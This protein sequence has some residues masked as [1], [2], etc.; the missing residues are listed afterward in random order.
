MGDSVCTRHGLELVQKNIDLDEVQSEDPHYV[1]VRKAE[2]AFKIIDKPLVVSDDSW[3]IHGLNGFPGVYAKSINAWF[4]TDDYLRLT[5][6]LNDRTVTLVQKLVYKDKNQLKTFTVTTKG[7]LLKEARGKVGAP[8]QKIVSFE[9]DGS[10][11]SIAETL[12]SKNKRFE[13]SATLK[14]W[15]EFANWMKGQK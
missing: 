12:A 11:K 13:Q 8:I 14:V 2:A 3:L 6:D 4:T 10:Q 15:Q 5:R 7:E 1:A 9:T